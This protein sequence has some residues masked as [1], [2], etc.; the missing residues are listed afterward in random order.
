MISDILLMNHKM[1]KGM[2]HLKKMLSALGIGHEKIDVCKDN[3]MLFYRKS[4]QSA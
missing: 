3:Y 2:Y 1:S 4:R